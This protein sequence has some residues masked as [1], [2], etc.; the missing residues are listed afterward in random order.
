MAIMLW[1][2]GS[3]ETEDAI[4]SGRR[5]II[6]LSDGSFEKPPATEIAPPQNEKTQNEKPESPPPE[7]IPEPTPE[8]SA[9][10]S[11][12]TPVSQSPTESPAPTATPTAQL[13]I[14]PAPEAPVPENTATIP[15]NPVKDTLREKLSVGTL[16]VVASDGTKSWRYYAKPYT[17]KSTHPVIAIV[18]T[19]LGQNKNI[20]SA[21]IKLPENISLSFSA[22]AK[23]VGTWSNAARAKGHE[24]LVDLPLEPTNYP[25]SDPGPYGLL[26]GKS[27][28][29][30]ATRLQWILGRI[31]GYIGFTIPTNE[32][33]SKS[34]TNV[35]T[36][37]ELVNTRGLMIA[38]PHEPSRSE[39]QKLFDDS[40]IAY[41]IA[42]TTLDE[43]LTPEAIQARF[44]ALQKIA[45]KRGFAVGY[46]RALPITITE[47]DKWA[48]KLE[49]NGYT[50]APLSYITNHKF[51]E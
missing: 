33:F 26:S 11:S 36:L 6:R 5:L 10:P 30:N 32:A 35:R 48:A 7:S 39:T 49:E 41:T 34:D 40:K 1:H 38:L 8:S 28:E 24:V 47:L 18:V 31:Q 51:K 4:N 15:L 12:E 50:L 20:T 29:E 9:Q 37:L 13:A 14:E 16:P 45:T 17:L 42:D 3:T 43:E 25:A 2:S 44:T 46:T 19:G 27:S 22:Y 23:D 21:A